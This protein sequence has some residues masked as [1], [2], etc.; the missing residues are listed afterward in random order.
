MGLKNKLLGGGMMGLGVVSLAGG[1]WAFNKETDYERSRLQYLDSSPS[2]LE[3][4]SASETL[5][6]LTK[7][8]DVPPHLSYQPEH[9]RPL[10]ENI[11]GVLH[12]EHTKE[13]QAT[14]DEAMDLIRSD[15][16]KMEM[17]NPVEIGYARTGEAPRDLGYAA[18]GMSGLIISFA[19][20]T[21]GYI[22]FARD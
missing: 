20:L 21:M 18:L 19:L 4:L 8:R 22:T 15:M 11:F 9:V 7:M 3:Y 2:V 1:I 5:E 16:Q 6:N 13:I 17:E 12:V 10:L 14:I